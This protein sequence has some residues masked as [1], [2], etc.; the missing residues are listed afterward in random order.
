MLALKDVVLMNVV[1]VGGSIAQGLG[2][3]GNSY[4]DQLANLHQGKSGERFVVTNFARSAMQI[5]EARDYLDAIVE[6]SPRVV[7]LSHGISEALV[8]PTPAA[9]RFVP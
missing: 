6:L 7:V 1:V 5:D 9:I 8:R 3:K 4:A 2:V